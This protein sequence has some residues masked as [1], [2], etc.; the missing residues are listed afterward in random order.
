MAEKLSTDGQEESEGAIAA[1]CRGSAG[2]SGILRFC[3]HHRHFPPDLTA[4]NRPA[5]PALITTSLKIFF[6][7][8]GRFSLNV[9][10]SVLRAGGLGLQKK[11]R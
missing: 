5:G 1:G 6:W 9:G 10:G 3:V 11:E 7:G 4:L 2:P 8:G